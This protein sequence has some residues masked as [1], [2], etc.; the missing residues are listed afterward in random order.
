MNFNNNRSK[1]P[2][3][4]D[5][6]V[7][8]ANQG[9][10][11]RFADDEARG[12][13]SP[14]TG[15]FIEHPD[16]GEDSKLNVKFSTEPVFSK[17]ETYFAEG[18][19]KYVDMD[20]VT[21]TIPGNRDLIIHTP[22]TDFYAWRFPHEHAAFKRGQEAA[23][24]GTPLEMWPGI[25]ASQVAE[26]KHHGIRTVEQIATLSDSSSGVMRGFYAMK[27][28]AQQFLD[29]AKDKN[30][31]AFVRAQMDEQN[32]RHKAELQAVEDRFAAMLADAIS[33][34][35]AKKTKLSE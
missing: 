1:N 32:E 11:H 29:D 8:I 23:V 12:L 15:R 7:A 24:I 20:F 13:R 16:I 5:L 10:T 14:Q 4:I 6:D 35:E 2:S 3:G 9:G 18:V 22:V 31:T 27:Q 26:L 21:I 34:R 28:K 17:R 25:L 33:P 19:P 30:A